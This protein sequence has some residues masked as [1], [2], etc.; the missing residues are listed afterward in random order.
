MKTFLNKDQI[1]Y[2]FFHLNQSLDLDETI[3]ERFVFIRDSVDI[4]DYQHK[5]IFQLSQKALDISN[6]KWIEQIPILFPLSEEKIYYRVVNNNLVFTDDILKSS[7]Y[8]L[9]GFQEYNC[10]EKD[11]YGRFPYAKSIQSTLGICNLPVVN[12]YFEQIIKGIEQFSFTEHFVVQRKKI[13]QNFGFMLTHD[14]DRVD[15]YN[16][17]SVFYIFKQLIGLSEAEYDKTT[18]LRVFIVSLFYYV[19]IFSKK[20]SFWTF[21]SMRKI[22]TNNDFRSVFYVLRNE[23]KLDSR[24]SIK[25]KRISNLLD[26]LLADKC[27]IGIHGTMNSALQFESM[28][29]ALTELRQ[30]LNYEVVGCRQHYL[31]FHNPQT[32]LIQEQ[33]KIQ[34]DTTLC[35]AEHEGFRNSYCLPF[36]IYHFDEDRMI[37]VWEFPLNVMEVTLFGYRN[38]NYQEAQTSV[39]QLISEVKKFNGVFT[40]LWHNCFFDEFKYKGITAFYETLISAIRKENPLGITGKELLSKLNNGK[41]KVISH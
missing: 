32:M 22:E 9:S 14:I 39:L 41:Q 19:N 20:N 29:D 2:V 7:F 6:V 28:K 18:T 30:A 1:E 21:E 13:F 27:E 17:Y 37:D 3:S 10:T 12:Y 35:F 25:E 8:L 26:Y 15:A 4:K 34:Y 36:K 5:I 23:G 16:Y 40:L 31:Q 38:M 24:Y 11:K 33:C